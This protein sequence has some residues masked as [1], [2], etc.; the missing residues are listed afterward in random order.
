MYYE[1]SEAVEHIDI[2][3][4][5]TTAV[6]ASITLTRNTYDITEISEYRY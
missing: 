4:I 2:I 5:A 3:D 1:L 6:R